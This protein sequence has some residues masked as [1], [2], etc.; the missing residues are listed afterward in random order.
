MIAKKSTLIVLQNLVGL[1]FGFITVKLVAVNMGKEVYGE[2][3][4]GLTIV[5]L[6][7]YIAVIGYGNSH[8]KRISEGQDLGTCIGTFILI[9]VLT[10]ALFVGTFLAALT[11]YT[12]IYPASLTDVSLGV[13][14]AILVYFVFV[15]LGTIPI[16]TFDA[17][18]ETSKTQLANMSQ[19]PFKLAAVI[20]V[21][22]TA[23]SLVRSGQPHEAAYRLTWAF[24]TVGSI[25]TCLVAWSF[26]FYYKYPVKK[27]SWAMFKSYSSFAALTSISGLLGIII[28]NADR[29]MLNH[30]WGIDAVGQYFG[31]QTFSNNL[32]VIPIA[33]TTILMPVISQ[34][35]VKKDTKAIC[36]LLAQS[37]RHISL[38]IAPIT[39][40]IFFFS[41]PIIKLMLADDWLAADFT[42]SFLAIVTFITALNSIRNTLLISVGRPD[43]SAV[44]SIV[45]VTLNIVVNFLFIPNWSWFHPTLTIPYYLTPSGQTHVILLTSHTGAAVALIFANLIG[46]FLLRYVTWKCVKA[47]IYHGV[48]VK[49][50]FASVVM[51]LPLIYFNRVYELTRWYDLIIYT[52]LGLGI[53]LAVLYLIKEFKKC[54]VDF[55][56]GLMNPKGMGSYIS[57]ELKEKNL[58]VA[59]DT[60]GSSEAQDAKK[61]GPAKIEKAGKGRRRHQEEE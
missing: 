2:M 21:I 5:S 12:Y 48:T 23:T 40:F 56:L 34:L 43:I 37:E 8:M 16:V 4:T 46:F 3:V 44:V 59:M 50:V 18:A 27:P 53:Y 54:D 31:V 45:I 41:R 24:Y 20:F 26:F 35:D 9:R 32:Q 57:T 22:M 61:D 6:F 1:L 7:S 29:V 60:M 11:V 30:Y 25:V 58:K 47:S 13:I 10:T 15:F 49:H 52:I 36:R 55:Y 19:H 38:L 17:R 51:I 28:M 14:L 42:L 39:F 33:M